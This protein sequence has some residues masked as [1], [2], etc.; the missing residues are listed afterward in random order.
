VCDLRRGLEGETFTS[1]AR[2]L[3]VRGLRDGVALRFGDPADPR[4]TSESYRAY[5]AR[6]GTLLTLRAESDTFP[7]DAAFIQFL[8]T[9]VARLD[10]TG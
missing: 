3:P 5:V 8:N 10:A 1:F 4:L 6:R 7:T 2:Q 9:A